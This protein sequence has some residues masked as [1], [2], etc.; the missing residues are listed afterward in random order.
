[1]NNRSA[2]EIAD[3]NPVET[4]RDVLLVDDEADLLAIIGELLE[5]KGLSVVTAPDAKGAIEALD[6]YNIGAII[7]DV[8]LAGEDGLSLMDYITANH[9]GSPVIIYTGIQHDEI[10][11]Q[12]I[13]K[14]GATCYVNKSQLPAALLFAVREV[15]QDREKN[16]ENYSGDGHLE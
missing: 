2:T 8:N 4:Y 9:P 15:L 1:M 14:Q 16:R 5:S 7:L 13:L 3:R 10:Q 12:S 6:E 11:V